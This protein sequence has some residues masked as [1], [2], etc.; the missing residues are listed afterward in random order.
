[1]RAVLGLWRDKQNNLEIKGFNSTLNSVP[2]LKIM[3][4]Y[5]LEE[6]VGNSVTP[7][8]PPPPSPYLQRMYAFEMNILFIKYL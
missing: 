1:M 5:N 4:K 8:P 2:C 7:T 3:Y 6:F